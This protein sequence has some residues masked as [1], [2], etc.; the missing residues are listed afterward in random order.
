MTAEIT[1]SSWFEH[2]SRESLPVHVT[3]PGLTAVVGAVVGAIASVPSLAVARTVATHV[4]DRGAS[5]GGQV[6]LVVAGVL[7]TLLGAILCLV[8]MQAARWIGRFLFASVMTP[9]LA[10]CL[11]TQLR[12]H[13]FAL[14]I[15]PLLLGA[16]MFGAVVACVPPFGRRRAWA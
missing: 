5:F 10:F 11:Y 9:A 15:V 7:G 6:P 1:R 13:D 14:P 2:P 12:G 8:M 4:Y 16:W 3:R